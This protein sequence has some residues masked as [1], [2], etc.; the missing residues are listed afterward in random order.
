MKT[1]SQY[2]VFGVSL[3]FNS[4]PGFQKSLPGNSE[5]RDPLWEVQV[6]SSVCIFEVTEGIPGKV[7]RPE[8]PR[9]SE[10]FYLLERGNLW[11]PVIYQRT[12]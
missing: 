6:F 9:F 8:F 7:S 10:V 2:S 5:A 11:K 12:S 4:F 1:T 3:V